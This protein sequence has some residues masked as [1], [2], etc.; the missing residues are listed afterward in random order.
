MWATSAGKAKLCPVGPRAFSL[1]TLKQAVAR[2]TGGFPVQRA[3]GDGWEAKMR[4]SLVLLPR[5]T[6][7]SGAPDTWTGLPNAH[8]GRR[9]F[10]E[11]HPEEHLRLLYSSLLSRPGGC[12]PHVAYGFPL[13]R[14]A[15]RPQASPKALPQCHLRVGRAWGKG[16]F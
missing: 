1:V 3:A 10:L 16:G 15:V 9:A 13:E 6:R 12:R 7:A 2:Q 11:A 5:D 14:A 8:L 4:V